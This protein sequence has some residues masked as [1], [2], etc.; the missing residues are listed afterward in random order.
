MGNVPRW[1]K[2][3]IQGFT[4]NELLVVIGI[5]AVL[6][7][8][9]LPAI[10]QAREAARRTQCRNNLK[11]IGLAVA[12]Y[13]STFGCFPPRAI[14]NL[15]YPAGKARMFNW[16]SLVLPYLDQG[17]IYDQ[18][19][20]SVPW[21]SGTNEALATEPLPVFLCPSTPSPRI[22]PDANAFA[23]RGL[24]SPPYNA[25]GAVPFGPCDYYGQEGVKPTFL[26]V[27]PDYT[28]SVAGVMA[29]YSGTLPGIFFHNAFFAPPTRIAAV[30]D[31]LSGT[32]LL[33]EDAGRPSLY[34]R[35]QGAS[36]NLDP[37]VSE[38][39]PITVDGWGWADTEINGFTDGAIWVAP[40][41]GINGMND[42]EIYSF[43]PGG[44]QVAMGDGSVRFLS[45]SMDNA[46]LIAIISMNAR[47]VVSGDY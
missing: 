15:N 19:N 18:I 28:A 44:A 9:L 11:Q 32:M 16:T 24:S 34:Y 12:N 6:T 43:H 14:Y 10:Q 7:S 47:D 27:S 46:V 21:C 31:G 41:M 13:E 2:S 3:R 35:G 42:S 30:S 45:Q 39:Q 36:A 29:A 5:I 1:K 4:L 25:T 38:D 20:W 8:L 40:A 33:C 26:A 17:P 23:Q 37:T 22:V